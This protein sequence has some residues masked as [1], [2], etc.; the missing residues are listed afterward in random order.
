MMMMMM[1][2]TRTMDEK[3]EDAALPGLSEGVLLGNIGLG[4]GTL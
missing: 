3:K 1:M 2:T 4:D